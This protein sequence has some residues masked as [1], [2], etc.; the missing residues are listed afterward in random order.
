MEEA[1]PWLESW[2][3]S[4]YVTHTGK[5]DI[6]VRPFAISAIRLHGPLCSVKTTGGL[7]GNLRTAGFNDPVST[8]RSGRYT[9]V[10]RS[11]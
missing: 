5:L 3:G 9:V 7:S 4:R 8:Q 1:W 10:S 2:G 11:Y 6:Y